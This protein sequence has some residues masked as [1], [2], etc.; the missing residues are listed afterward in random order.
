MLLRMRLMC[1]QR[2][3]PM[4][5]RISRKS[6]LM[7]NIIVYELLNNTCVREHLLVNLPASMRWISKLLVWAVNNNYYVE[8]IGIKDDQISSI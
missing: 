8:I 7:V 4:G 2:I 3:N 5:Q 6:P 1:L